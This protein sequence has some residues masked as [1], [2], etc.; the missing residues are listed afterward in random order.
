[1]G[2]GLFTGGASISKYCEELAMIRLEV[3]DDF[4]R[5]RLK[6]LELD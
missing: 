3:A 4:I 2:T 5:V 1:M 6:G